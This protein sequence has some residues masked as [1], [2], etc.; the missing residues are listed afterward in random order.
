MKIIVVGCGKIGRKITEQLSFEGHDV[1]VIDS[2]N[3]V[4][5]DVSDDFDVMGVVGNGASYSVQM[6]AG[7]EEANLLIAATDSDEVNLLC[8]MIAKKAG[9]CSTIARVRNPVY[10]SEIDFIKEELGLAMTINPE[11]AAAQEIARILRFPSA[12]KIDTFS[13][14]R[15]EILEFKVPNGSILENETLIEV[16]KKTTNDILVCT[17]KR[18]D[19]VRIPNGNFVLRAGD[20]IGIV[21]S[22]EN[23]KLFFKKVGLDTHQVKDTM[24]IGGG[25]I[26]YYL[27]QQLIKMGIG[28][29]IVEKDLKRCETLSEKLPSAVIIN[30]DATDENIL[31][32]EGIDTCNSFVSLT[33]IDE[34]NVFLSLFAKSRN[35]AKTITKINRIS[36]GTVIKGLELD[37]VISPKIITS[38]RIVRYVRAMQNGIGSNVETL[39]RIVDNQVEAL[40][41]KIH[42]DASVVGVALEDLNLKDNVLIACI[43]HHGVITIP[44][45]KSVIG[46]GDTVIVVTTHTGLKDIR[47]ILKEA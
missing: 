24:I 9:N 12:I 33:G 23:S 41:F 20:M 19:K 26:A 8:C 37:S 21:A 32:E 31:I 36:F 44:N 10:S 1:V 28:I 42:S 38:E 11:F 35:K 30:G 2:N 15:I 46:V 45:G 25:S 47:D 13:K 40:E 22:P 14:G 6:E 3:A 29:K 39:Y 34:S 27:A 17:V 5:Q 7:I 43:N 18:G 16:A 4:V